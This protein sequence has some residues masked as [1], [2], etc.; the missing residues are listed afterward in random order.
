MENTPEY[1]AE[2]NEV[3]KNDL[4]NYHWLKER[5]RFASVSVDFDSTGTYK[6]H[7]IVWHVKDHGWISATGQSLDE[8]LD[9]A[10][11]TKT[12]SDGEHF[13]DRSGTRGN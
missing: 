11:H 3:L 8:A 7:R 1:L 6:Q 5:S 10:R 13:V 9:N 12:N 4:A 2:Q